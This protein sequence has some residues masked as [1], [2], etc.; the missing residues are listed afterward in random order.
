MISR[1]GPIPRTLTARTG[2]AE[3]QGVPSPRFDTPRLVRKTLVDFSSLSLPDDVRQVLA[4]A[5]WSHV[6]VRSAR[7]IRTQWSSM[8][9]FNRFATE[10]GAIASLPDLGRVM[11]VRYIEW[12]NLQRRADGS[13]WTLS[14]RAAVYGS[15]RRLLQ[16]LERCR[17]DM[18]G[19]IEY[20]Y[21]PFPGRG[22]Y[23]LP[24]ATPSAGELR[25]ILHASEAEIA[26]M[27]AARDAAAVQRA[28]RATVDCT[29]G[30]RSGGAR[31]I[32]PLL[33]PRAVSL[34]PYYL[35]I[36]IHAAGNPEPIAELDR[37]CLQALPLMTDRETLVWFKARAGR[38][39][40]RTFGIA[41]AFEPP[42]L[43]RDILTWNERL[44][45]L[46]P[47]EQRNRLFFFKGLRTV[48]AMSTITVHHLLNAFCE[49]HG[50]PKFALASIRPAVLSSFYRVSGDLLR[51]KAVANHASLATT[52]RYVE[53]PAVQMQ[54]R[55]RIAAMQDAFI[56]HIESRQA[57]DGAVPALATRPH[58]SL[59]PGRVVSMFGFDC[60]DP[61]AG[62]A[63]GTRQGELCT[64]FMGCFTCPN[65]IIA[66]DP[67]TVARL[68]QA[69]D[70]LRG[71]ATTLHPARWQAFYA[72]QLRILEEDIL[73]RFGMREL[74]AGQLLVARLP[75]LP[76]LR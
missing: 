3:H 49:R 5:F 1:R 68:L 71:A 25:S 32:E 72:P 12:L 69:R 9:T 63:P 74:A 67:A 51:T 28:Q 60:D 75:A 23:S 73:P 40:R 62:I 19:A 43:V 41:N 52:V 2:A 22:R 8:L 10:S 61:L 58:V 27:R 59:P 21:S 35:A 38:I 55:S 24:R 56:G 54:N 4:Q 6:G 48:N 46:A 17:P 37:D 36:L 44:R 13:P 66:P 45:R 39:Q 34:L 53:T 18:V 65:A 70:H 57:L 20:P 42:A 47:P 33:Y 76:D 11:L 50:L 16:W 26:K 29:P 14:T 7:S 15:L 31:Q 64:S 30:S